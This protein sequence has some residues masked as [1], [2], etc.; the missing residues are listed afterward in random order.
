MY[1]CIVERNPYFWKGMIKIAFDVQD[2]LKDGHLKL[3]KGML[4]LSLCLSFRQT[5]PRVLFS[6]EFCYF[7]YGTPIVT[8]RQIQSGCFWGSFLKA[9]GSFFTRAKGLAR[10]GG[11]VE[12]YKVS[13]FHERHTDA[14]KNCKSLSIKALLK[15]N[16]VT[17]AWFIMH[18]YKMF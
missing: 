12:G 3:L 1:I 17:K 10:G 15:Q 8:T 7:K 2:K 9:V 18:A 4:H 13:T 11:G 16:F 5:S 6:L 14:D